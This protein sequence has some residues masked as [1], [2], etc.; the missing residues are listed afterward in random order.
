MRVWVVV[1]LLVGCAATSIRQVGRSESALSDAKLSATNKASKVAMKKLKETKLAQQKPLV[2]Q[3]PDNRPP[4][5]INE[6]NF[7]QVLIGGFLGLFV[8]VTVGATTVSVSG[9]DM[10]TSTLLQHIASGFFGG[11]A[12]GSSATEKNL[13]ETAESLSEDFDRTSPIVNMCPSIRQKIARSHLVT[14]GLS[15]MV[16]G[17]VVGLLTGSSDDGGS[18]ESSQSSSASSSGVPDGPDTGYE[19]HP[20][21]R[22]LGNAAI[23]H[24]GIAG[25]IGGF[26][27][28]YF[29]PEIV[30][31]GETISNVLIASY[32][33]T[34]A[35]GKK[36]IALAEAKGHEVKLELK[37][38]ARDAIDFA[39]ETGDIVED[40]L[41]AYAKTEMKGKLDAI[42]QEDEAMELARKEEI[43]QKE[44]MER[45]AEIAQ[46][47]E[48]KRPAE[49][50]RQ[51]KP[52]SQKVDYTLTEAFA[53][54]RR[55]F[56]PD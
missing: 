12:V 44:E 43:A 53:S 8:G 50:A 45:Q 23:V 24:N 7:G 28:G 54:L 30:H 36:T 18:S 1:L 6:K 39:D 29:S 20:T 40:E 55:I 41:R 47:D 42:D 56:I 38:H 34:K 33:M 11:F 51:E 31:Y 16:G 48:M 15:G 3:P 13:L 49:L 25:A 14:G 32:H 10:S 2:I 21:V 9:G 35:A 4:I 17:S 37:K 19:H 26:V 27:A 46:Q 5:P 22:A 52:A